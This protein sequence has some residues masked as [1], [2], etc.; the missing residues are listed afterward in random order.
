LQGV[1]ARAVRRLDVLEVVTLTA[2]AVLATGAGAIVAFLVAAGSE[3]PFRPIWVVASMFLFVV[4]G[5]LAL[6]TTR[7]REPREDVR[8][9]GDPKERNDTER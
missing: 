1:I 4:P 7:D 9:D 5:A 8:E 6:W 2:A 3:L